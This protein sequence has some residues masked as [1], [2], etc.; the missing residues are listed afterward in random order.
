LRGKK[1]QFKKNFPSQ[2]AVSSRGKNVGRRGLSKQQKKHSIWIM[3]S[4]RVR[5]GAI[6]LQPSK[7]G[8]KEQRG[9]KRVLRG[10]KGSNS[11]NQKGHIKVAD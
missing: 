7:V 2:Q 9:K 11:E 4:W 6:I 10:R 1:R 8:K 5:A 3:N